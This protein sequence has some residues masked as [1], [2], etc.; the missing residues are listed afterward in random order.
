MAR[1]GIAVFTWDAFGQGEQVPPLDRLQLPHVTTGELP[2]QRAEK[3][4]AILAAKII[5]EIQCNLA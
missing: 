3:D 4:H 2:Q 5:G 1:L